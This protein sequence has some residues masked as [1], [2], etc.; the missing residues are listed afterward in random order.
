MHDGR[1]NTIWHIRKNVFGVRQSEFA[2]LAGVQQSTVSR[3]ERGEGSPS[4]QEM[5]AIRAAAHDRGHEWNDR[6]FFEEMTPESFDAAFHTAPETA[7]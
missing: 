1:M 6:W 4:L 5:S 2:A 3:W 7:A